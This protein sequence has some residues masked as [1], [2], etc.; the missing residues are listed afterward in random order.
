M[1]VDTRNQANIF[2]QINWLI[3]VQRKFSLTETQL[4]IKVE[5]KES[6]VVVV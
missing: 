5:C 2:F 1:R 3:M 6:V 4:T